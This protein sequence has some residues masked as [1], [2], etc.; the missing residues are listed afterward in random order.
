MLSAKEAFDKTVEG[1][2]EKQKKINGTVNSILKN[3]E[4]AVLIQAE[5]GRF[6]AS[7]STSIH[8]DNGDAVAKSL[9]ETLKEEG[10]DFSYELVKGMRTPINHKAYEFQIGWSD[11]HTKK[12]G[13]SND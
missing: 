13:N 10:Y 1:A 6:Q 3:L 9:G 7:F 8:E 2:Q 4:K 12:E 5:R 11:V